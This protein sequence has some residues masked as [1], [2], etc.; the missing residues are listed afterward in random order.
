[1]GYSMSFD[2]SVKCKRNNVK[3]L[4]YHNARD[5]DMRNGIKRNHS[6][7]SI[8]SDYTLNNQTYYYNS[9]TK[10]F[11]ECTDVSQ[12]ENALQERLAM[13]KRPLRKDAVILRSLILQLDPEWYD[14]HM[15][16]SERQYSYKCMIDWACEI[17]GKK[18][19]ISYSLH[20]DETNPH[21]HVAFT[22][23]T[24]DGRLSQKDYFDKNK[25]REQHRSLRQY[26]TDKGFEIDLKNRKPGK[27]ARRM[28][29]EEYR[30]FAELQNEQQIL[31]SSFRYNV[32]R[33]QELD[34]RKLDLDRRESNLKA[35]EAAFFQKANIFV[36]ELQEC[37]NGLLKLA[38][39]YWNRSEDDPLTQYAKS[40]KNKD[41]ISFYDLYEKHLVK[42]Q[43][44]VQKELARRRSVLEHFESIARMDERQRY[45][46]QFEY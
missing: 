38:N 19:I 34:K 28:S 3:G 42:E 18:N 7:S 17:F 11:E 31:D 40:V 1:M 33:R 30:D 23:V 14:E 27:Y 25:L 35:Q 12:I 13:V 37:Q 43:A 4:I 22:P 32:K 29:V 6:N 2:A 24:E 9:K 15:D 8:D 21:I 10:R 46:S 5:V 16:E 20:E 39:E 36:Q 26:M 44:R 41:G 45:S